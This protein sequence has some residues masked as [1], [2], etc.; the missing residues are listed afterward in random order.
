MSDKSANVQV[1][2][3]AM[4]DRQRELA[5]HA[6]GLPNQ[7]RTSYRNHFCTGPGC[8]DYDDWRGMV[9]KGF[10]RRRPGSVLTGG[11][12]LFWLTRAGADAALARGEAL[13]SED[14][15]TRSPTP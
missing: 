9:E 6:L 14:F 1:L 8:T 5:R 11:D 12:D 3:K 2:P 13:D 4:T 15:P 7:R 10:A